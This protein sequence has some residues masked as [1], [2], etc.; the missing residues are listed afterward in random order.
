MRQ[1]KE[2]RSSFLIMYQRT[3]TYNKNS[4]IE[5]NMARKEQGIKDYSEKQEISICV[6]AAIRDAVNYCVNHP[7][8]KDAF[9][10]DFEDRLAW[11]N[12][13]AQKFVEFYAQKKIEFSDLYILLKGRQNS[14]REK[15]IAA[16]KI[17]MEEELT[18][19]ENGKSETK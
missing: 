10:N 15:E 3:S 4:Q 1:I 8:W 19:K 6:T 18:Q 11:I 16:K 12:E 2:R 13:I 17:A 5:K 14:I 7:H 9:E